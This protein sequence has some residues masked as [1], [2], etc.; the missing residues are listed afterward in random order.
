M[1]NQEITKQEQEALL[2]SSLESEQDEQKLN[3]LF[4]QLDELI[5]SCQVFEYDC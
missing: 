2:L 5:H 3:E 1:N 4:Q